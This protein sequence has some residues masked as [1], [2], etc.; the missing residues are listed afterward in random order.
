[1]MIYELV[2]GKVCHAI[3]YNRKLKANIKKFY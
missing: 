2:C 3:K 1:M